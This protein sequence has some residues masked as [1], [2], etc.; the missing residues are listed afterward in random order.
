MCAEGMGAFQQYRYAV[1]QL[2]PTTVLVGSQSRVVHGCQGLALASFG[3]IAVTCTRGR[4]AGQDKTFDKWVATSEI[5]A[6]DF[7]LVA[8]MGLRTR[9]TGPVTKLKA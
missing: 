7:A 2:L 1:V 3:T 8:P 6:T 5:D 4:V 9:P